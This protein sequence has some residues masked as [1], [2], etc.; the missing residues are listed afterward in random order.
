MVFQ[1]DVAH[2]TLAN[3]FQVDCD[4]LMRRCQDLEEYH[5]R[6]MEIFYIKLHELAGRNDL[7]ILLCGSS[8][9]LNLELVSLYP[10]LIPVCPS[11]IAL[12]EPEYRPQVLPLVMSI[13]L[14]E[15]A[16]RNQRQDICEQ[17]FEASDKNFPILQQLL[18]NEF[19]E[20]P[21]APG[22]FHPNR[23]GHRAMSNHLVAFFQKQH[24]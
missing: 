10:S 16:R 9:D 23:L 5:N 11:W 17:I 3:R 14:L 6:V 18:E 1:H 4:D 8:T 19:F 22:D 12:L 2:Q 24:A 20:N 13:E 15:L 21:F 7:E